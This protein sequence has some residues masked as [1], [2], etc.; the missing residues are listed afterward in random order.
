MI[1][2]EEMLFVVDENNQPLEPKPRSFVH[3]NLIWHRTSDIWIMNRKGEVLCQKRSLLKDQNPGKWEAFFGGHLAPG[4]EYLHNA[5][6]ETEEELGLRISEKDL[7]E[8][9][10]FKSDK[11]HH[12]EFS[13]IYALVLDHYPEQFKLEAEEIEQ[14]KWV[15][16]A[17]LRKILMNAKT[18]DWVLKPWDEEVLNWLKSLL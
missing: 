13:C 5:I 3:K 4:E 9:K 11:P 15:N 14:V 1:D 6:L 16:M 17:Q 18:I 12:K 10:V 2:K 7:V 8:Y